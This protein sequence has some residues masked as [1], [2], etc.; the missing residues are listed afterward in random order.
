MMKKLFTLILAT[1]LVSPV[2]AQLDNAGTR[3]RFNHNNTERYY[4]IRLGLNVASLSSDMADM[5]MNSRTGLAFG[6]VYGIQL[7]NSMPIWLEP[8]LYYSE[9][10]GKTH[11]VNGDRVT[12]RISYLEIP[13]VVKYAFD[14]ADDFYVTPFLGGFVSLGIAGKVKEYG[15]QHSYSSYNNVNRPD[16]GLRIGCGAEYMMVYAELGF[17]FGLANISKDDFKRV[18]T[19]TFFINVGVDF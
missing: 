2:F 19:Q 12:C 11:D 16:A 4:G 18:R 8:G 13:V 6:G 1:M 5:D 15:P 9:K 3:T 17:D 14:V 7:A 10:G